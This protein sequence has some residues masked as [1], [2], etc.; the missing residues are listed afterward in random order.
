MTRVLH[1]NKALMEGIMKM[2]SQIKNTHNTDMA[3]VKDLQQRWAGPHASEAQSR[4][5]DSHTP[6][7]AVRRTIEGCS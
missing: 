6:S 7:R 4:L 1:N 5:L 2:Q 3:M